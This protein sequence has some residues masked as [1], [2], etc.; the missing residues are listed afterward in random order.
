[1]PKGQV[2]LWVAV[3]KVNSACHK[4][5][6]H[7]HSVS[8][9]KMVLVCHMILQ[10]HVI[11]GSLDFSGFQEPVQVSC[12]PAMFG[13]HKHRDVGDIMAL[14]YYAILTKGLS[15]FMGMSCSG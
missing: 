2:T 5:V 10:D 3:A 8:G 1:M 6:A 12:H 13:S 15:N 11:K 7:I 9:D 14:V 4:V